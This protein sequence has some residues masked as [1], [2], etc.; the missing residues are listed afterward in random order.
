MVMAFTLKGRLRFVISGGSAA[1]Q[2][3]ETGLIQ[4]VVCRHE[5]SELATSPDMFKR[6]R[7]VKAERP[8]Q[9][10]LSRVVRGFAEG[11]L[12]AFG[13]GLAML[14]AGLPIVL[15]VRGVHAGLS[16]VVGLMGS[17]AP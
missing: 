16:F 13:L 6:I 3:P 14:L 4:T 2:L 17:P 7:V 8:R 5:G 12:L 11:S 1:L 15:A 10:R 9:L